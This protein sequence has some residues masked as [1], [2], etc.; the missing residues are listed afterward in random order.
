MIVAQPKTGKT[1]LLQTTAIAAGAMHQP[2]QLQ[3]GVLTS[4]PDEWSGYEEIPNNVG[5]FPF[6]HQ[7]AE[8][9]ILS[10]ASW[11]HGN[12]SSK[13][14]ILLLID[15]LEAIAKLDFEAQQNLRWLLLRGP[16][17]RV[18]P[19]VTINPN[20]MENTQPWLEAFHTRVFGPIQ[21]IQLAQQMDAGNAELDTLN[22]GSQFAMREGKHWLR[23]WIPSII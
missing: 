17:R 7:S 13:Q 14:S 3:F 15:D 2:E 22:I 1:V 4:H 16:A 23:F 21:N 12:K 11:A 5:I 18:W 10:L 9:F 6:F 19:I 8:D 20:R